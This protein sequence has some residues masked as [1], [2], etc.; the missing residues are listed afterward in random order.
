VLVGEQLGEAVV[1]IDGAGQQVMNTLVPFGEP[2]PMTG[3]PQLVRHTFA[4][5]SASV[6]DFY[7]GGAAKRPFVAIEVPVMRDGSV[8]YALDIGISAERLNRLLAAQRVPS[9]WIANVLDSQGTIVA[10]T[11]NPAKTVGSRATPDLLD[12]MAQSSEGTIASHTLEG[13]PSFL[14]FSRSPLSRW[15]I[16]VAMRRDVL[17][18]TLYMRIALAAAVIAAFLLGGAM[19][20]WI[21][22][23]RVREALQALEAVTAAATQ[24]DL[25]AMAPTG[26]PRE[27][28]ELGARFNA[29]QQARKEAKAQLRLAA[30]VFGAATEGIVIADEHCR[31]VDVNAAFTKLTGYA[32]DDV[33]GRN[34]AMLAAR[35]P[36]RSCQRAYARL[37]R[38][39]HWQGHIESR[40]KDTSTFVARVTVSLVQDRGMPTHFVALFSDVTHALRHQQEVERLAYRDSLT[41]LPNRRLLGDRLRQALSSA[42]RHHKHVAV[43]YV[44]LDGF[45]PINDAYGHA[46]GDEVLREVA[47][48]LD[49]VTR[50]SDTA[51]RVGGD[52]FVLVLTD[53]A[54][55]D[56]AVPVL[57]RASEALARPV[58]VAGGQVVRLSASIGVAFFP[59]DGADADALLRHADQAMYEAKRELR[60][61]MRR[62]QAS[63]A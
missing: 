23:R 28:A 43:C 52:E 26:G 40:R 46:M 49:D 5:A 41:R 16:A 30:S 17:Y 25:D 20:A 27:I 29:M 12:A 18:G 45:K 33:V 51:A 4:T 39:R 35:Q 34:V 13:V 8:A 58:H 3:H 22:S 44:D 15:T 62:F 6:S 32:R 57:S 11:Q 9:G 61:G 7:L 37:Q 53:L 14:A 19:L 38:A 21:F 10:R 24:G 2:L 59:R 31:V 1:L 55:E 42:Q 56:E 60:E 54:V 63:D 47:R 50:A 48:R 36:R